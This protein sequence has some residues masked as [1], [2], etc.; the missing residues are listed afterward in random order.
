MNDESVGRLTGALAELEEMLAEGAQL[1][2]HALPAGRHLLVKRGHGLFGISG[3]QFS[4]QFLRGLAVSL[5]GGGEGCDELTAL[6]AVVR[7]FQFFDILRDLG[8]FGL[9]RRFLGVRS[10][11]VLA[12]GELQDDAVK[13]EGGLLEARERHQS[14]QE[15]AGQGLGLERALVGVIT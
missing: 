2:L 7:G 4:L 10:G 11:L 9:K 8:R 13:L 6:L 12:E 3:L 1:C 14:G 5:H 15:P